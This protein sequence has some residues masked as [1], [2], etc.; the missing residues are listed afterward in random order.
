MLAPHTVLTTR[1]KIA[2]ARFCERPLVAMRRTVGLGPEVEVRRSGLRWRLDLR[3]GIDFSI[4]VL[5]AFE[6]RLANAYAGLVRPG[7]VVLDIGANVGAHTLPLARLVGP[8]GR[9]LAFE[10]TDWAFAKLSAN[11]AL[12]PDLAPR[13]ACHQTFLVDAD[14]AAPPPA[15]FSSWPL[16]AAD[17]HATLRGRAMA[18]GAAAAA[19]LDS[20]LLR[21]GVRRVDF[22]KMDV[23]GHEAVVLRGARRLLGEL[24]PTILLEIAPYL[25]RE[26]GED[27]RAVLA[28]MQEAGYEFVGIDG[29][30]RL[31][32]LFRLPHGRAVNVIARPPAAR[33]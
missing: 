24:R 8:E 29:E 22:V 32:D 23:D 17:V 1:Q 13:I 12:N 14:G 16:E 3:E 26:R 15:V 21:E 20:V 2:L 30:G 9:V 6:R 27:A 4:Y 28:P 5:G 19:T 10:P 25:L 7:A 11:I 31:G 33:A 18:T